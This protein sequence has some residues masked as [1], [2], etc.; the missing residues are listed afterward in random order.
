[1]KQ[2]RLSGLFPIVNPSSLELFTSEKNERN[3][4]ANEKINKSLLDELIRKLNKN[5]TDET[6]MEKSQMYQVMAELG[7]SQRDVDNALIEMEQD[8]KRLIVEHVNRIIQQ[9]KMLLSVVYFFSAGVI[10]LL[11]N[12][13][14]F[15][16]DSKMIES[17]IVGVLGLIGLIIGAVI[18]A[19]NDSFWGGLFIGL[20][21]GGILGLLL[22]F[23]I[24]HLAGQIIFI[25]V[26]SGI[27]ILLYFKTIRE[28]I[29]E[30][31]NRAKKE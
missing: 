25:V 8:E 31:C 15:F 26:Y 24:S 6:T 16:Y 28:R 22:T 20:F 9:R 27:T 29:E 17:A 30:Y 13:P 18:G 2:K 10:L 23:L 5:E 21:A 11:L 1:M 3:K 4:M 12:L 19:S 7:Y 14:S